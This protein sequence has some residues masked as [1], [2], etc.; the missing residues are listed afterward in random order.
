[1]SARRL[2]SL[3]MIA[4]LY[5]PLSADDLTAEISGSLDLLATSAGA[6]TEQKTCF[7]CHHQTLPVL[8]LNQAQRQGMKIDT[9][10][11]GRQVRFTHRYFAG[12]REQLLKGKGVPGGPFTAGYALLLLGENKWRPDATTAALVNYLKQHQAE[13]GSWW[14]VPHRHPME[15]SQFTSTAL[16]LR[17]LQLFVATANPR[18]D[19]AASLE[20][21]IGRARKWLDSTPVETHED[22]VFR[23]LG[24]KWSAAPSQRLR[25][26]G[27]EL[28]NEQRNDGG[29]GQ[30]PAMD[31][32]A[33]A[34]GQALVALHQAAGV[35]VD[36][37][38][39]KRGVEYL[40][41]DRKSDGSWFVEKRCEPA[42]E[43]F[44]SG[45]PHDESQFISIA[46]T[47]WA[48]RALLYSVKQRGTRGG[49]AKSKR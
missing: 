2:I 4:G 22:K 9:A 13:D 44:E 43:Y 28:L 20:S 34:T 42:Q 48:T 40:V 21:R 33:Y 12:R 37:P 14:I 5:A 11:I 6:Y 41:K 7:S 29:W 8:A 36:R 24:L 17:G 49:A 1:M 30:L 10:E 47:S 15:Q 3:C 46:A 39:F 26:L 32:D 27:C 38:A 16:S 31:S 45:F 23:L 19:S 25:A 18:G 35:T